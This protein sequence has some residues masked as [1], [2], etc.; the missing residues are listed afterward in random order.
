MKRRLSPTRAYV[1]PAVLRALAVLAF[2]AFLTGCPGEAR[3]ETRRDVDTN[4]GSHP[5]GCTTQPCPAATPLVR[6]VDDGGNPATTSA[7]VK[8]TLEISNRVTTQALPTGFTDASDDRDNFKIEVLDAAATGNTIPAGSVEV[9]ALKRDHSAFS[10]RRKINV[11]LQRVGT[12]QLFRSRYLRLVVDK[13]DQ[14]ANPAQT[15]LTDWDRSDENV[16]ILGQI[17]KVTYTAAS[18]PV[19]AETTVGSATRSFIRLAVHVLRT[20]PGAAGVV[21]TAQATTRVKKWFRRVYAQISMAPQLLQVREV[22][23]IENLIAI[24]ND[25][26]RSATGGATSRISFTIRSRR[27]GAADLTQAIG[28]YA[29]VAGHTPMQTADAIATLIRAAPTFN[30]RTVQNPPTLEPAIRQG[31]A[32]IIITDPAGGSVS[33]EGLSATDA[34]QTVTVGVVNVATFEGYLAVPVGSSPETVAP[35]NWVAGS[36]MQRTLLQAYD[37][38]SD[39]VDVLVIGTFT[40]PHGGQAMMPGTMYAAGKQAISSVT[41][42][43]FIKSSMMNGTNHDPF[44]CGHECGHVLLDATHATDATQ[45]MMGAYLGNNVVGGPKR[46]SESAA[47]FDTP[48]SSFVQETRIR[49]Q[50]AAALTPFV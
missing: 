49:A 34:T 19:T 47:A 26:G 15:V 9:E 42:S 6:F 35:Q 48:A 40:T 33:I 30:A 4:F 39:R 13:V 5:V 43:A 38:G 23:P 2:G 11:E 41:R 50:G 17:V 3:R 22:D 24:S 32:D 20:S 25:H 44:A 1:L 45:L 27:T 14:A 37:T 21:T 36:I 10:P 7:T 31:S 18:G 29:L 16:E 12:S 28:P 8:N 46:F